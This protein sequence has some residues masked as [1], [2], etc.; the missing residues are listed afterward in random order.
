MRLHRRTATEGSGAVSVRFGDSTV[1]DADSSS[2]GDVA[3]LDGNARAS[4]AEMLDR[5]ATL[6][7]ETIES[8]VAVSQ[9]EG[10]VAQRT[11]T[12]TKRA[13]SLLRAVADDRH[14][15]VAAAAAVV[16]SSAAAKGATTVDNPF[17][18][19][20]EQAGRTPSVPHQ[21]RRTP[22]ARHQLTEFERIYAAHCD[23]V[24]YAAGL[25]CG[26]D[27]V[28][29]VTRDVFVQFWRGPDRV[30]SSAGDLRAWLV[31]SACTHALRSTSLSQANGA[32][33]RAV[34][35]MVIGGA[36]R[37]QAAQILGVSDEQLLRQ[38]RHGLN[39]LHRD[40]A[41]DGPRMRRGKG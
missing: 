8:A 15:T 23:A 37:A 35:V 22:S 26:P 7:R 30:G 34:A 3:V 11:S 6:L 38:L 4:R 14:L 40:I 1:V 17:T 5:A 18:D 28:E 33:R 21:A 41:E 16:L 20:L 24:Y 31:D 9:A 36:S 12:G 19:W 13:A 39:D 2:V 29:T 27:D 10:V 25:F 32:A